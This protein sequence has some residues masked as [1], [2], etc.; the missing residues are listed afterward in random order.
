MI[1]RIIVEKYNSTKFK[2]VLLGYE[3]NEIRNSKPSTIRILIKET[4]EEL[5]NEINNL[6]WFNLI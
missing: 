1:H 5:M 2:G 6:K 4:K 3:I